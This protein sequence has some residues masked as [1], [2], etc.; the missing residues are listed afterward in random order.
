MTVA[1]CMNA[2]RRLKTAILLNREFFP[3]FSEAP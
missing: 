2:L 1:D 3:T